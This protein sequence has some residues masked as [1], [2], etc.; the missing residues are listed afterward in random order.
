MQRMCKD[1]I[2]APFDYCQII[3]LALAVV[4]GYVLTE[5]VDPGA[6][7]DMHL[8]LAVVAGY[9]LTGR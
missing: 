9:M 4:A 8:A 1:T 6:L 5:D 3:A 7:G 2:F